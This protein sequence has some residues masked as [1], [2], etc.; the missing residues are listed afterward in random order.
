MF[1]RNPYNYDRR[2]ASE[3]SAFGSTDPSLTKQD[4]ADDADINTILRRFKLGAPL[5]YTAKI[6]TYGD[7]DHVNDFQTALQAIESAEAAFAAL[8]AKVRDE[9][10]NDPSRLVEIASSPNAREKFIEWGL[11]EPPAPRTSAADDQPAAKPA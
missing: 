11:I 10:A 3:S 9:L 5:P 2:K 7:F 8:P 6:P 1:I 4:Q